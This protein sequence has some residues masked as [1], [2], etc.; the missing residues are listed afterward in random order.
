MKILIF[1]T[2]F[3][4]S[5]IPSHGI[6]VKHRIAALVKKN[7]IIVVAPVP[8]HKST[9]VPKEEI[10][11]ELKVYHPRYF[12]TPK[13][14]RSLYGI[15]MFLSVKKLVRKL[16]KIY[17]FDLIDG[18]FIYPDG[19]AAVLLG[20]SLNKRVVLTARGT[21]I[22]W[23]PKF[24]LIKKLIRWTLEKADFIIAVS[25]SLKEEIVKLD[26]AADK[27]K[28]IPNGVNT[29]TFFMISKKETSN[30]VILSVGNL[31]Q[32]KGFHLLIETLSLLE[33]RNANLVIIGKGPYKAR[34]E[35]LV[36][37]YNLTD[38]VE[39]IGKVSQKEL[40]KWYSAADVFCLTSFREGRPNVVLEALACGT[41][42]VTMNKW[43]LKDIINE[44]MGVLLDSY[45]PEVISQAIDK[46]LNREWDRQKI[47]KNIK[48]F[49][50]DK[51]ADEVNEIFK[52]VIDKKDII[53]FSSDDWNSGLKTSKYHLATRLARTNRVFFINSLSLRTPSASRKD[54]TKIFKKL[55]MFFKGLVKVRENL[56]VYTPIIVP[57]HN[58]GL[59]RFI[60][61]IIGFMQIKMIINK[62]EI[63][64]PSI[65]A[66]I[67]NSL[68]IIDML[69][70]K[71]LIYYCVDD[72]SAFRNV[73]RDIIEKLDKELTKKAD[74]IFTASKELFK[75]KSLLN[76]NTIYSPHGVDFELFNKA[77][78]EKDIEIPK[79]LLAISTPIIGFYG[80]ISRDW[81][82]YDLVRFIARNRP[83]WS[84]VMIGKIDETRNGLPREKNIHYLPIKPYEEL[85]KYARFFDAA[86]LPFNLN[87]LTIH[88]HPLKILEYLSAGKPVVSVN[89]PEILKYKEVIEIAM[90]HD[91]FLSKIEKSLKENDNKKIENRIKFAQRNSW[92]E[93]FQKVLGAI[94]KC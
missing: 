91:D 38:K 80:L 7:D 3:P 53:F 63:K 62:F 9:G 11:D 94:E 49:N 81:I 67:P 66:F 71:E 35:K 1:T 20:K 79:D 33:K 17:N 90:D 19:L 61:K 58:I 30:K 57:L 29:N 77:V 5:R 73:G 88:S 84:I 48:G 36:E 65:W 10:I 34:L 70:R 2:L 21:D 56:Y 87:G 75:K 69:K 37:K 47:A 40:H 45:E 68:G 43:D 44:D 26:I 51:T 18:H 27:I 82:D 14:F 22:N 32:P 92:D 78:S 50:W 54:I 59:V 31:L 52:K 60:N 74:H 4:N 41:P 89:I 23:Y 72:M 83:E 93:R 46:A 16:D 13:I 12:M 28:M 42:V 85:Y 86:I 24:W 55:S 15:F 6:F 76:K 64:N 8:W 25:Q 39:F